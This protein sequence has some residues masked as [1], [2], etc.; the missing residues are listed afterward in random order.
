MVRLFDRMPFG[1]RVW[2]FGK[3][4]ILVG[5]LTGTFLLFFGVSMRVALRAR[6]VKVPPLLGRS[7]NEA[8]QVVADLGM[9]LRVDETRRADEKVLAGR[10]MQQDP[11]PGVQARQQRTIRVWVSSGPRTTTVPVLVGQT[12]RT[13]I[14]LEQDGL[15][16]DSVSEFRSPDYPADAV[17]A[18]DPPPASRAP[19]VSLLLN[20]GEQATTYVMPDVIGMDG[21]RAAAVLRSRGF[22]VAIVGSQP[23][24]GV[25]PGTVVRQQPAGG[26]RVAPSDAISLEVSR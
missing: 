15:E 5:A 1:T 2:G 25:P 23:Y 22:R 6:E 4:L 16:I 14:R 11:P 20:R 21:E 18:Q 13:R 3:I 9:A 19:K 26:F 24:A 7:V 17:V 10:I 12:E 8:N